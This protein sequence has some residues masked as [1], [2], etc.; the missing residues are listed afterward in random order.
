MT[1]NFFGLKFDSP[2]VNNVSLVLPAVPGQTP[3]LHFIATSISWFT[4]E[5]NEKVIKKTKPLVLGHL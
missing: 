4:S 3:T 5:Q 1:D 2:L